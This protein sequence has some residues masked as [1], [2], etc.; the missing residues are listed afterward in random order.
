[1]IYSPG[2]FH[3]AV[4]RRNGELINRCQNSQYKVLYCCRAVREPTLCFNPDVFA[5]FNP[6]LKLKLGKIS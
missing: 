4:D 3:V 6:T 1:M 2:G 5:I